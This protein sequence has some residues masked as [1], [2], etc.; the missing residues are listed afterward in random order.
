MSA[1]SVLLDC[2]T[3]DVDSARAVAQQAAA[4]DVLAMA[5]DGRLQSVGVAADSSS[6]EPL[7][8]FQFSWGSG[9]VPYS[10]SS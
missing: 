1:G 6:L 5:A 10:Q 3:V 2:S 8:R 9:S 7:E 4:H